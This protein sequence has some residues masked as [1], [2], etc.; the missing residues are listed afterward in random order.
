ML[1]LIR[2][3]RTPFREPGLD[4]SGTRKVTT[5][6]VSTSVDDTCWD[7][8]MVRRSTL[9]ISEVRCSIGMNSYR[10]MRAKRSSDME[11]EDE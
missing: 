11:E 6:E 1:S 8:R 7:G 3:R 5:R 9:S 10:I 4:P 2:K